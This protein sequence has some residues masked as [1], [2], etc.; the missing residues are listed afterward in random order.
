MA[1]SYPI[2]IWSGLLNDGHCE[3]PMYTANGNMLTMCKVCKDW[4]AKW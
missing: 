1:N 2:K 4:R 3:D